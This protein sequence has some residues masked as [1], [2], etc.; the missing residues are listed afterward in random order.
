MTSDLGRDVLARLWDLPVAMMCVQDF[1]G[2]L[3][4]VNPLFL[5][6]LGW[7]EQSLTSVPFWEF[8]H[9]QDQHAMVESTQRL[10]DG[11]APS[12]GYQVR[13]LRRDGHYVW[14]RWDTA[15]TREEELLFAVGNEL[16]RNGPQ[17]VTDQVAAGSWDW[18]VRA[19]AIIWSDEVSAMFGTPPGA[20]MIRG[21][22]RSHRRPRPAPGAPRSEV[23][24]G[25]W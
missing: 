8:V 19:N 24:P 9:S 7:P 15:S 18:D 12:L 21:V 22:P 2:Y 17:V 3:R 23:E 20:P 1:D 4:R 13:M 25:Q 10:I 6:L 16:V 11:V 14:T 5:D